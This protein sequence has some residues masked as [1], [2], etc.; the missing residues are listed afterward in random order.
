MPRVPMWAWPDGKHVQAVV[1][2]MRPSTHGWDGWALCELKALPLN[3]WVT[4][5][6]LVPRN[7]RAFA[8]T[9]TS[10]YKRVPI[11][12]TSHVCGPD[13]IRPIDVHSLVIR[14]L[15]ASVRSLLS[16]WK[17]LVTQKCQY[18]SH[19]G[20]LQ[21]CAVMARTTE[22]CRAGVLH[23]WS[24]S[25]DFTKLFNMLDPVIGS[26]IAKYAGLHEET[27]QLLLLPS[28][29]AAGAWKLP[30]GS[31]PTLFRNNRGLG[32]GL[33]CSVLISELCI[34]ALVF[35]LTFQSRV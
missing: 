35:R 31:C 9:V 16:A 25:L 2:S 12:K 11:P 13:Q 7:P 21:A 34:A 33:S 19:G 4:L 5:M 18:A 29:H 17:R 15:S 30:L 20:A 27:A 24:V 1:K 28:L 8:G 22:L 14:A 3:A 23:R 6:D 10:W 26:S 32:Q